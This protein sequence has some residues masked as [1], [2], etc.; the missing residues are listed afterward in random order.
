MAVEQLKVSLCAKV[1]RPLAFVGVAL[2]LAGDWLLTKAI[3]VEVKC[4]T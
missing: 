2:K 4:G 3:R 1:N